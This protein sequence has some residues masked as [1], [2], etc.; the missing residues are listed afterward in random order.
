M[1]FVEAYKRSLSRTQFRPRRRIP[2]RIRF[3]SSTVPTS[4][5]LSYFL[6]M[7]EAHSIP[8]LTGQSGPDVDSN[9]L[10]N[11]W[12]RRESNPRPLAIRHGE[13]GPLGDG[14]MRGR[15]PLVSRSGTVADFAHHARRRIR[16]P[17]TVPPIIER[18][19]VF[20]SGTA[21]FPFAPDPL[22]MPKLLFQTR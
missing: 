4:P 20:G 19:P 9:S 21:V 5:H 10:N 22:C 1:W 7:K 18:I 3:G 15:I 12:R 2:R 11:Q 8:F 14:R 17:A 6:R 16:N 13:N